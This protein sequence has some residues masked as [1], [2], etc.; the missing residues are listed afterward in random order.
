MTDSLDMDR[1][2]RQ[3][4]QDSLDCSYTTNNS[5]F[6]GSDGFPVGATSWN[7][8]IT[9]VKDKS[10]QVVKEFSLSQNYPNPFNPSTVIK[11]SVPKAQLVTLNI[12]N[13]L[14][15]KVASLVNE[16]KNPGNYEVTFDA[17][18]LASG[19]YL[20][21]LASGNFVQIKKMMLLK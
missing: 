1:H 16:Q 7:S 10:P 14:G 8:T 9:A 21:K 5:A 15:Q 17:S 18:K 20:Y 4:W 6:V 12:Y 11:Y 19:V 13:I 3:Y 2:S